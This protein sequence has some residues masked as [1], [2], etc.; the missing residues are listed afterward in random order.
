MENILDKLSE[1]NTTWLK[2]VIS[3]GC[4]KNLAQDF[5]QEMYIKIYDYSLKKDNDL[6]FNESEVNYFFI[7]VTLKN[8]YFD[9]LRMDKKNI[10]TELKDIFIYDNESYTEELFNK[11]EELLKR[12]I[13]R[14]DNQIEEIDEYNDLKSQ[15]YYIK[16]IFEKVFLQKKNVTELSKELGISYWSIRNTAK[17]IKKQILNEL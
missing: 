2:Y 11:R 13:I 12:W 17:I 8:M 4:D 14:L 3:F 6:M 15:L 5:V 16:F 1:K 7:Y 10:R 9:Y